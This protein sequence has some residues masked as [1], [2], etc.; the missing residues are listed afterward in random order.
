MGNK[1][2]QDKGRTGNGIDSDEIWFQMALLGTLMSNE[3]RVWHPGIGMVT[4]V[5]SLISACQS[6]V[7][8]HN[9]MSRLTRVGWK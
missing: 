3:T 1:S 9:K 4:F 2:G 6:R 7:D 8:Q 5:P